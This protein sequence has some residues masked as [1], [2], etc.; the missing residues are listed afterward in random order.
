MLSAEG[1][2]HKIQRRVATPAFS[3]Q[4]MR[5]LVPIVFRKGG[6]LKERWSDMVA[7][8]GENLRVDV[9]HWVSR[10]TFDVIGS[11]GKSSGH[12][13]LKSRR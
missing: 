8:S 10:A 9:G 1:H 2:A 11:A 6:Q 7:Q 13:H 5:A 3:A 12:S 4:N